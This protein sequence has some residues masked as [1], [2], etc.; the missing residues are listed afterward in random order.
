L[1]AILL[2]NAGEVVSAG[3]LVEDLWQGRAPTQASATLKTYIRDLRRLLEPDRPAGSASDVLVT[4]RPGYLLRVGP[5]DLDAWRFERLADEGCR[6]LRNSQ[7]KVA[8]EALKAALGLWRGR[9]FGEL[10]TA[11]FAVAEAARLE[12]RHLAGLEARLEA[13]LALGRHCEVVAELEAL[14]AEHPYRERLLAHLLLALYR[15]GRQAEALRAFSCMRRR[16]GDELGIEPSRSVRILEEEILLQK[17]ELDWVAPRDGPTLVTVDHGNG[18]VAPDRASTDVMH[19]CREEAR[20]ASVPTDDGTHASDL[21]W[22]PSSLGFV[23]RSSELQALDDAWSRA[24]CGQ[25]ALVAISGEEGIGKTSL[26]VEFARRVHDGG[27]LVLYGRWDEVVPCPFQAFREALGHYGRSCSD[28][29]LR[30]D[31]GDLGRD[32]A[33]LLPDVAARVGEATPVPADPETERYRLFEAVDGWMSNIGARRPVLLVLDDLHWADKPSLLLLQHL[34]RQT[35][36]AVLVLATICCTEVRSSDDVWGILA[37]LRRTSRL[38]RIQVGA[39]TGD[40]VLG[41]LASIVGHRLGRSGAGF[42]EQLGKETAGNPFFLTEIARHLDA[43]GILGPDEGS[44]DAITRV[45]RI[46]V[47]ECVR[48]VVQARLARLS[49]NCRRV[50][51]AACVTGEQFEIRV[52]GSAC[53]ISGEALVEAVDEGLRAGVIV[54]T[55]GPDD[56]FAFAHSV[57]RRT[58]FDGLT[59]PRRTYLHHRVALALEN[60]YGSDEPHLAAL[61]YHFWAGSFWARSSPKGPE[62]AVR[63]ACLAGERAVHEVAY[64]EAAR[65]YGRAIEVF[66]RYQLTDQVQRCNMLLA[67]GDAYNRMG[68]VAAGG[69]RFLEVAEIA[70]GLDSTELLTDAAL[71]FG[72]A[73][74]AAVAPNSRAQELL[75]ET[76]RAL[77]RDDS[78]AHAVALARLAHWSH[79]AGPREDRL[80]LSDQAVSIA[81]R[82][83]CPATLATV[84]TYCYWA[85]DGPDDLDSRLRSAFEIARLGEELEDIE[86]VL[87][88]LKCQLHALFAIGEIDA[89][90]DVAGRM[91][92][93]ASDLRQPEYVRLSI[94]WEAATAAMEGRFGEADRLTV[95]A[96][97]LLDQSGHPQAQAIYLVQ[98]L[99]SLW[100]RGTMGGLVPLLE[101]AVQPRT[102]TL[103]W[104]ALLAWAYA[105]SGQPDRARGILAAIPPTRLQETDRNFDWW[106][107]IVA[108]ANTVVRLNAPE[109]VGTLQQLMLPY[110]GRNATVGQAS[111]LGAVSHHLGVLAS[112]SEQWDD[113]IRHLDAALDRH[114]SMRARPFIGL[115]QRA[116]ASALL[117]RRAPGDRD[118]A[119]VLQQEALLTTREMDRETIL[120]TE[121]SGL[122]HP[123]VTTGPDEQ[124]CPS[125]FATRLQGTTRRPRCPRED[126]T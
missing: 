66:D 47:P 59:H 29:T 117:G 18:Q 23:G 13:D 62:R 105:E 12:E 46:N 120:P 14:V 88:G 98:T 90:H 44:S 97:S 60:R 35:K 36:R 33:R 69:E 65:Q 38:E 56:D 73:L 83:D 52:I 112:L 15:A 39:L 86:I 111:F 64:E 5:D 10:S 95:E 115:T 34:M 21:S 106:I 85:L 119:Q 3:R 50:L 123:V 42:A 20:D 27:G 25:G 79:Y 93:L 54:Q 11:S 122:S 1:L 99:P 70:R 49:E 9:P 109:W 107:V 116:Y 51:S 63:Y 124:P 87:Q 108:L 89:L 4:R 72:G 7:P 82:L 92:R 84:L 8:V 78:R 94:M 58:L 6:A 114:R 102:K 37:G 75:R 57:V 68:D 67:L 103:A 22:A 61:A 32:L 53:G 100:L 19:L 76:L 41:V 71:G 81:R 30:G 55:S 2:I 113:A 91:S 74:P 96:R 17:P 110:A 40:E 126:R 48:E 104:P 26:A 31:I 43:A 24:R 77:G 80:A 121:S 45:R 125:L 101:Q 118:R 28:A 16:L